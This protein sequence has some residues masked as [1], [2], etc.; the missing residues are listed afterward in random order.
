MDEYTPTNDDWAEYGSYCE[1][2]DEREF[3]LTT[4][5]AGCFC[6]ICEAEKEAK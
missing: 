2:V 3:H 6:P 4:C 1:S 5:P